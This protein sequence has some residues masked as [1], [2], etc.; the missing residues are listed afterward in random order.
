MLKTNISYWCLIANCVSTMRTRNK[1]A[2]FIYIICS[3]GIYFFIINCLYTFYPWADLL[4]ECSLINTPFLC[5]EKMV[6]SK[7]VRNTLL[8]NPRHKVMCT[9]SIALLKNLQNLDDVLITIKSSY[10][11]QNLLRIEE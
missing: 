5:N 1:S 7:H 11:R 3:F 4:S 9:V 6:T 10:N 2:K 8:L